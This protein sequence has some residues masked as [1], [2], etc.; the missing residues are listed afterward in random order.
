MKP[1]EVIAGDGTRVPLS[2][3]DA[4]TPERV[5]VF[6]PALGIQ[7]KMYHRMCQALADQGCTVCLMEQRGHGDSEVT[8][9]RD[10]RFGVADFVDHDIPAILDRVENRL[11]GLPVIL[12][13]HSLGGHLATIYAGIQPPRIAAVLH[14]T[15]GFPYYRDFPAIQAFFIRMLCLA[16]S[17]SDSILGYFPGHKIGFGGRESIQLM[18]DWRG[19][20]TTG[21]FD[22]DGRRNVIDSVAEFTGHVLSISVAKDDFSCAAAVERS[23][24]PFSQAT[25]RKVTLGTDTQGEYLGHFRWAR[26][27]SGIVRCITSWLEQNVAGGDL[28]PGNP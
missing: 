19:W 24:A 8:I 16:V 2:W 26:G 13:G 5:L 7:A 27:P 23:L 3:F 17:V 11:A 1:D 25:V 21:R 10:T 22:F 20:A 15:C 4:G 14:I 18:Q 9:N 28:Q 12:G 6:M